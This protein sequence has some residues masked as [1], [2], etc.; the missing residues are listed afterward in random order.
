MSSSK[1]EHKL[2]VTNGVVNIPYDMKL[3]SKSL[4]PNVSEIE[5]SSHLF[6]WLYKLRLW[7]EPLSRNLQDETEQVPYVFST[8]RYVFPYVEHLNLS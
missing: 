1:T 4:M 7:E 3:L 6:V 5:P 2:F 8:M